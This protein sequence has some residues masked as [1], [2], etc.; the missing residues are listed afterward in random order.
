MKEHNIVVGKP[1]GSTTSQPCDAKALFLGPKALLR[2]F[3]LSDP[4]VKTL[5]KSVRSEALVSVF[6]AIMKAQVLNARTN[7]RTEMTSHHKSLCG[8]GLLRIQWAISSTTKRS[9]ITKSYQQVG[10][11]PYDYL[12]IWNNFTST[13][14]TE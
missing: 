5:I 9:T 6:N 2:K 14:K 4:Q 11:F 7:H 13:M 8:E 3:D 12:Q 10:V 1:P